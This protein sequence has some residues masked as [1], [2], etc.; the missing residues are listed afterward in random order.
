M[1]KDEIFGHSRDSE[2]DF[3]CYGMKQT[4]HDWLFGDSSNEPQ[5]DRICTPGWNK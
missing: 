3:P 5:N 2:S 4:W 1:R